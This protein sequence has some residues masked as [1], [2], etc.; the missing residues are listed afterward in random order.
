MAMVVSGYLIT[1]AWVERKH[2]EEK[3]KD[4]NKYNRV[5]T[6]CAICGLR[7]EIGPCRRCVGQRLTIEWLSQKSCGTHVPNTKSIRG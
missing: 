3:K 6:L 7:S 5:L 4:F 2:G 1:V